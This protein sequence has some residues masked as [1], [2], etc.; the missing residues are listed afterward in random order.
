MNLFPTRGLRIVALA[1]LAGITGCSQ[2][3]LDQEFRT[4]Y[5]ALKG[6]LEQYARSNG[7]YPAEL[8]ELNAPGGARGTAVEVAALTD[9]YGRPYAYTP[10]QGAQPPRIISYGTDGVPG[11][12]GDDVDLYAHWQAR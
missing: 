11:D 10:P 8:S 9:P 2:P 6:A 7:R 1:A 12:P 4:D 5:V 3:N